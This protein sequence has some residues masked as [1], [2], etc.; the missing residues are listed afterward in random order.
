[1]KKYRFPI[2]VEHDD[3]GYYAYVPTLQGCYTQGDT[4]EEAMKNIREAIKGHVADR[5]S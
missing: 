4:Y 2:I 1:M 5:L 3:D